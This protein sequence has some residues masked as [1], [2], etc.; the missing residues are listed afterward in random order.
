LEEFIPGLSREYLG[1][2][3]MTLRPD[4]TI[5]MKRIEIVIEQEEYDNLIALLREADVR[6][7]TSIKQAGGL[8]SRGERN[9]DESFLKEDNAVIILACEEAQ[10][11]RLIATL[12]PRLKD[13]GGMC[14]VS[15][16]LWVVGPAVSY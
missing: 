8:G 10:A 7:Y 15:D 13:F 16:C 3:M 12:R 14:L 5:P 2:K 11:E 1:R 6:G 9:P 4:D